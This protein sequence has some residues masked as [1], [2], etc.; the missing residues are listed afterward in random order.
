MELV[1]FGYSN[2]AV[3]LANLLRQKDK[4]FK[5]ITHQEKNTK[6]AK[7]AGFDVTELDLLHKDDFLKIGIGKDVKTLFCMDG[8]S[9][10][11]LFV[12]LNA[13][14]IDPDINI[15]SIISSQDEEIKMKL[16]GANY[17]VDP[18]DLGSH[19]IYRLIKK[20]RVF[21]LLDS[22]IFQNMEYKIDEVRVPKTSSLIGIEFHKL[23]IEKDYE[24]LLL[25]VDSRGKFYY[26]THKVYHKIKEGDVFVVSGK[27]KAI[28]N[29]LEGV[30]R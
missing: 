2:S 24:L 18:Y 13:R 6:R 29:F 10:K 3:E 30:K 4:K 16:A 1:I 27:Q 15:I 20:P 26:N 19:R 22:M 17:C 25:G 7:D 28:E 23:T 8:S 21:D 14:N 12:T 5:I 11:N 9:T